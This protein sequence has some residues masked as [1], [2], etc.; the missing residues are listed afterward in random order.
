MDSGLANFSGAV[1]KKYQIELAGLLQY[2]AN[3][4]KAGKSYDLLILREMVQKM[5]GIE[6]SE[7]VTP[8]QLEAMSGG[9]LL[10]QEVGPP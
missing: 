4:L 2:V 1:L 10:R 6:V 7:E 8:E 9:E 5:T 3:Q